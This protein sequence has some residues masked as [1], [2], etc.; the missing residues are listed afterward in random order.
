MRLTETMLPKVIAV[1]Q[2][3]ESMAYP[4]LPEPEQWPTSA[5]TILELPEWESRNGRMWWGERWHAPTL[6]FSLRW[7]GRPYYARTKEPQPSQPPLFGGIL[8]IQLE[9]KGQWLFVDIPLVLSKGILP[10]LIMGGKHPRRKFQQESLDEFRKPH[11]VLGQRQWL[12]CISEETSLAEV[13]ANFVIVARKQDFP[14]SEEDEEA[15]LRWVCRVIEEGFRNWRLDTRT[16]KQLAETLAREV[17]QQLL[18]RFDLPATPW[19]LRTYTQ[20]VARGLVKAEWKKQTAE[21]HA[22][23]LAFGN[24]DEEAENEDIEDSF[25]RLRQ[26]KLKRRWEEW[27]QPIPDIDPISGESKGWLY[28]PLWVAQRS[29]VS[30]RTVYRWMKKH[31]GKPGP[32]GTQRL[33]EEQRLLFEQTYKRKQDEKKIRVAMIESGWSPE[34]AKKNLQRWKKHGL[35]PKDMAHKV[36]Q[37]CSRKKPRSDEYGPDL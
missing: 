36:F 12:V 26:P 31:G 25:E 6:E 13:L 23:M 3:I 17:Y 10:R 1:L 27:S 8:Q 15:T 20:S 29:G 33:S 4:K 32:D 19:G 35:S 9:A 22:S 21:K 16:R 34:A 30:E 14:V 28:Y 7:W 37:L 5:E 11:P 24:L 2:Q 18:I